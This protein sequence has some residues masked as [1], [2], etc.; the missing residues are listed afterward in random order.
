M[1]Q[2]LTLSD[3]ICCDGCEKAYHA[4]C[5][6][7][8]EDKLPDIW[9]GPC[10]EKRSAK[11]ASAKHDEMKTSDMNAIKATEFGAYNGRTVHAPTEKSAQAANIIK[12]NN[13]HDSSST[14]AEVAI[15][16]SKRS[17]QITNIPAA[18]KKPTQ[19]DAQLIQNVNQLPRT[20]LYNVNDKEQRKETMYMNEIETHATRP[21]VKGG[22]PSP[23]KIASPQCKDPSLS[24]TALP[25]NKPAE[26]NPLNKISP[27]LRHSTFR[28]IRVPPGVSEGSMFHVLLEEGVK[29]GA[30]CPKGVHPGQTIVVLEPECYSVPVAPEKIVE[31]NE[32]HLLKGFGKNESDV[33]RRAFW[34][35][36]FPRLKALGWSMKRDTEYN[37]GAYTFYW[38]NNSLIKQPMKSISDVL[39]V[40]VSVECCQDAVKEFYSSIEQ[41]KLAAALKQEDR[42]RKHLDEVNAVDE[43]KKIGIGVN[44][45]VRSLPRAGTHERGSSNEYM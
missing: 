34:G 33:V 20:Q 37:F 18:I 22:G 12:I 24:T 9:Y 45:Q 44:Y 43:R 16:H 3:L 27:K 5:I 14:E 32:A 1:T 21:Y 35:V 11:K 41:H 13:D 38:D 40:A 10:C 30:I 8:D 42:K 23:F 26:V 2:S 7:V 4:E 25:C 28:T 31:M 36:L 39:K 15:A 6:N 17:E 29:V 19:T